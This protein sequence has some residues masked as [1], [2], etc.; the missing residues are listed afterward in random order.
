VPTS[1]SQGQ[2]SI[3]ENG[4]GLSLSHQADY[5]GSTKINE[6]SVG[7]NNSANGTY[8]PIMGAAYY[9][10]RGAWRLGDV[11]GGGTQNDVAVL[12]SNSGMGSYIND[13]IGH[14]RATAT[15]LPITGSNVDYTLAKGIIT[16]NSTSSPT[17]IGTANYTSDFFAFHT[18]GGTV[19][20]A[21]HDGTEFLTPGIADPSPTLRSTLTILNSSGA[22][23]GTATE[24]ASTLF[25]TFSGTLAAG[26]YYARID[27]YG[28]HTQTLGSYNTTYYYDMGSYFL[29]GS[30]PITPVPEPAVITM[31]ASAALMGGFLFYR[32]RRPDR[33]EPKD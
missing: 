20:L 8:A 11:S 10:Q 25:E 32:R 9:T 31:L 6:Y 24:D 1:L 4:H 5:Q 13:G 12:L 16:P 3:H 14:T 30:G 19:T 7:D 29:T 2:A 26:D 23:A 22:V 21:A 27:S 15:P 33:P 28:G 18:T 17:P